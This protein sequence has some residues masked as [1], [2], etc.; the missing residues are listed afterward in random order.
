[1]LRFRLQ[2]ALSNSDS[3]SIS[4]AKKMDG[5]PILGDVAMS[6][7]ATAIAKSSVWTGP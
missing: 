2:L 7:N 5:I 6:T 1:M 4:D 3:A